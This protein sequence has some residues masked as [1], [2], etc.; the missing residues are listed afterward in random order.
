MLDEEVFFFSENGLDWQTISGG[1][2]SVEMSRI[3]MIDM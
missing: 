3:E 1:V 2:L